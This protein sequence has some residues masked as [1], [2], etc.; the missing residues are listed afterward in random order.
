MKI[1]QYKYIESVLNNISNQRYMFLRDKYAPHTIDDLTFHK[2]VIEK[3]YNMNTDNAIPHIILYGPNGSGKKTI[4]RLLLENIFG[5]S[6]N[7]TTHVKYVVNGSGNTSTDVQIKQSDYHIVINPNNTNFD[8]YLIQ[9]IVME[10]AR[11]IPLDVYQTSKTFKIVVI[12]DVENLSYSAQMS[13]RRTMEKY[14]ETCRFLMICNSYSKLIDPLRSRC[15]CVRVPS[16]TQLEIGMTILNI[17]CREKFIIPLKVYS[18]ILQDSDRNIK[19]AIW[20]LECVIKNI[21]IDNCFD[22]NIKAIVSII[23]KKDLQNINEIQSLL[24]DIMIANFDGCDI[25]RSIMF[26]LCNNNDIDEDTKINIIKYASKYEH[27]LSIGRREIMH[28]DGFIM[29]VISLLRCSK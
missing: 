11:R 27:H 12:N 16:P 1:Q 18:Q 7:I 10:Y 15:V 19:N 25:I 20:M 22:K 24:Y 28:L 29:H 13:L 8:R 5:K 14:S 9:N 3:L 2:D 17:S 26:N 4:A 23:L 6:V 21:P